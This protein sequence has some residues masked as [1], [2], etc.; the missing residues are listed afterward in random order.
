[1]RVQINDE[2]CEHEVER[3]QRGSYHVNCDGSV[4][5]ARLLEEIVN[6]A[7]DNFVVKYGVAATECQLMVI[8]Y[9]I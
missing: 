5:E 1:M 7:L 3:E 2:N 6:F 9:A 8:A 4:S